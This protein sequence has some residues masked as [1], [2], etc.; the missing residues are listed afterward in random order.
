MLEILSASCIYKA[1]ILLFMI[2]FNCISCEHFNMV[3][4]VNFLIEIINRE[5][6]LLT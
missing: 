5:R 3:Y 2:K 1:F 6:K 4:L